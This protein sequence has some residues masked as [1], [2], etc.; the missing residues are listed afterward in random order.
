MTHEAEVIAAPSV[1]KTFGTD[2]SGNTSP[3]FN[4]STGTGFTLNKRL[5]FSRL[6]LGGNKG[7]IFETEAQRDTSD[8][9]ASTQNQSLKA[10]QDLLTGRKYGTGRFTV[11]VAPS[12]PPI[13]V[14]NAF[15]GRAYYP[16]LGGPYKNKGPR[17]G[18]Y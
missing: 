11:F 9:H 6:G 10:S 2:N 7:P 15:A 16:S 1:T 5:P 13:S 12:E 8:I 14:P 4:S 17:E 3:Q 18:R